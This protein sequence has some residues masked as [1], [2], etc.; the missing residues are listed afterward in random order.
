MI[1]ETERL[2]LR[3]F[4]DS[5]LDCLYDYR[6]NILCS[7]Y[8]RWEENSKEYLADFIKNE[9]GK[10]LNGET[11]QLAIALKS[12]DILIGHI[13]V[14]FKGKTIT[15]GYTIS[16]RHQRNGYAYEML[17]SF[18]EKLFEMFPTYEIACL[19]HPENIASKKLLE[20]LNFKNEGYESKINSVIYVLNNP[21]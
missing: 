5:D 9:K 13:Y 3:N 18:I 4:K 2:V 11:I 1:L 21:V 20:K 12:T 6:N 14:A 7:K 10:I 15:L 19:V 8:Q 16:Y 17:K